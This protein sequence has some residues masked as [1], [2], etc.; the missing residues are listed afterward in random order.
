MNRLI[1][2]AALSYG[3]VALPAPAR[4]QEAP[5]PLPAALPAQAPPSATPW[6][7]GGGVLLGL[8]VLNLASSPACELSAI[9]S[10]GHVPCLAM[11]IAFGG[12]FVAAGIPLLVV[13][14]RR[15]EVAAQLAG[16]AVVP[17]PGGAL[18]AWGSSW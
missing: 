1:A 13:G 17:G 5:P 8:G 6:L 12:A 18:V 14:A 2:L 9:R 15:R 4:A 3:T 11:S 10:S 16:L 7:V